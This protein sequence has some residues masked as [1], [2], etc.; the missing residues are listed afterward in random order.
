[1][2][3][4]MAAHI[5]ILFLF[6]VTFSVSAQANLYD[7]GYR[8]GDDETVTTESTDDTTNDSVIAEPLD[9][10]TEDTQDTIA[11]EEPAPAETKEC[12]YAGQEIEKRIEMYSIFKVDHVTH[13]QIL[14][15][16][17]TRFVSKAKLLGYD[18]A[19]LESNLNDLEIL[20]DT[21]ATNMDALISNLNKAKP[22]ADYA[23]TNEADY[24][25]S[26]VNVKKTLG[27]VRKNVEDISDIYTNELRVNIL[28]MEKKTSE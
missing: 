28:A 11:S 14:W 13:F 9:I 12:A 27:N 1:M 24:I 17:A 10:E 5:L 15:L 19:V 6:F 2:T 21:Y 8:P 26:Q 23:C 25:T 16:K 4:K 20:I 7:A 22:L 18:V 3:R